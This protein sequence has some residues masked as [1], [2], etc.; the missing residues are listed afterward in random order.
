MDYN[1]FK[2]IVNDNKLWKDDIIPLFPLDK[3]MFVINNQ[4]YDNKLLKN[5]LNNMLIRFV[6]SR[7]SPKPFLLG[8]L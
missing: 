4:E 8:F 6:W 7:V 3:N 5:D 2:K 1:N